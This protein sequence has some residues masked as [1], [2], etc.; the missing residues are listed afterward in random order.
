MAT[1]GTEAL[2]IF[3]ETPVHVI[4][5]AHDLPGMSGLDALRE[6]KKRSPETIGILLAGRD[7]SDG[8]EA[9]VGNQEVFQIIR[10]EVT[11]ENLRSLIDS[12]TT[13]ARLLALSESANDTTANVDQPV[14]EHIVMETS[15]NGS[16]IISD[17]TGQMPALKPE[18]IAADAEVGGR[19]IDVL[20]L[21]KDEE[22]LATV[23]DSSRGLHNVYHAVT[24][25]QA[26]EF[27][28]KHKVGVLVTDAAMVGSN[29]ELLTH[30]L[31]QSVPRLVAVVAG[32][33]DDGELLMDLINRGQVYRFLLKPVSPGRAR[34]AIEASVKH[35]LE[36]ADKAFK[37]VPL[38][39]TAS[40]P[41]PQPQSKPEAKAKAKAKPKPKTAPKPKV[42]APPRISVSR[43]DSLLNDRLD[44]A[45]SEGGGLTDTVTGIA[46]SVGRKIADV[47]EAVTSKSEP[48]IVAE[49]KP[50]KPESGGTGDR[51]PS[52]KILGLAA[53]AVAAAI[54]VGWY[55]LGTADTGQAEVVDDVSGQPTI[56]ESDVPSSQEQLPAEVAQPDE[57]D[58]LGE[59]RIARDA[60]LLISPPERN[61]VELYVA[62]LAESPDNPEITQELDLVIED[63]VGLAESAILEQRLDDAVIALQMIALASPLNP[64]LTFLR[65]QLG[66]LQLRS[67]IDDA[68]AAIRDGLFEDAGDLIVNATDLAGGGTPEIDLLVEEL[69]TA[70]SEQQIDEVLALASSRLEQNRLISPSNNNARYYYELA[71]SNDPDN[72]G[73]R[74]GLTIV[75]SKLVLRA[76][77]A[78]DAGQLTNA[79]DLLRTAR[80]LDPASSDLAASATALENAKGAKAQ[81]EEEARAAE[82]ER[83]AEQKR[84]EQ[85]RVA[86]AAAAAAAVAAA[87]KAE[88][89]SV[90]IAAADT[91]ADTSANTSPEPT[92]S[93]SS[94]SSVDSANGDT[95]VAENRADDP[96]PDPGNDTT[97][98]AGVAAGAS[99]LALNAGANANTTSVPDTADTG[100]ATPDA[101]QT[102]SES[103]EPETA[104][105]ATGPTKPQMVPV[106]TLTRVNYVAPKYPRS[107]QRR[108]ITGS[109][110]IAFTVQ[111]NGAVADIDVMESTPGTIFDEVA[112]NA[113]EQ[114]RFEPAIENG[115]PIE[116]RTAIRL[117]FSLK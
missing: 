15:E 18:K 105:L 17:G 9:L 14:G 25:T 41:A 100:Q 78:I 91:S 106:S 19:N 68:R 44:D 38:K 43:D 99:A 74:Q 30:R 69:S 107:A 62:A 11:P 96:S 8:L 117:A 46:F 22:F 37:A 108:N 42:K 104:S 59:A 31:R 97:S 60:G 116:K 50:A 93:S 2:N 23:K 29:I 27:A 63:V 39:G 84:E 112:I 57:V 26:D 72:T 83:L 76:R 64:R 86:A 20:V 88:T 49:P 53:A 85:R 115:Q 90:A 77:E 48:K 82:A 52:L 56:V 67:T 7:Q 110:D 111:R 4:V 79:E 16:V 71:L 33:R 80:S 45:F 36:A 113:V 102:V 1:S 73:A 65:A 55:L 12:A 6:A 58:Y 114:W 54:V 24:P 92:S 75:A 109:V 89:E 10:G 95:A 47:A 101:A 61:A 98:V 28:K 34:L 3:S 51:L 13:R 21:T 5:S 87:Q 94:E 32:R 40:P 35:H 81:V 103:A 66:Q 70:R